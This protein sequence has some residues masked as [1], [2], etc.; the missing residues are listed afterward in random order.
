MGEGDIFTEEKIVILSNMNLLR[1]VLGTVNH[2]APLFYT[3]KGS[4][5]VQLETIANSITITIITNIILKNLLVLLSSLEVNLFIVKN[6]LKERRRSF[7]NASF[8]FLLILII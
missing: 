8:M 3:Y 5:T 1:Y 4:N 2:T 6:G 7:S